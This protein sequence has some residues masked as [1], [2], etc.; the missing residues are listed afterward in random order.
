MTD[1]TGYAFTY[2]VARI[3]FGCTVVT[4]THYP[5]MYDDYTLLW[6]GCCGTLKRVVTTLTIIP[7]F[8]KRITRSKNS[9]KHAQGKIMY[10]YFFNKWLSCRWCTIMSSGSKKYNWKK[11]CDRWNLNPSERTGRTIFFTFLIKKHFTPLI[12]L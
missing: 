12:S 11:R 3:W 6:R 10:Q 7:L 1:T 2:A 8:C 9:L 5:T 4:Y